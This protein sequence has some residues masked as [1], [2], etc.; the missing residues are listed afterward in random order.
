[1]VLD[2][3]YVIC[4]SLSVTKKEHLCYW[5]S[6]RRQSVKS[7]SV[8]FPCHTSGLLFDVGVC[9]LHW[10]ERC[11]LYHDMWVFTKKVSFCAYYIVFIDNLQVDHDSLLICEWR[12]FQWFK[13]CP[14]YGCAQQDVITPLCCYCG[15][16]RWCHECGLCRTTGLGRSLR[17][18]HA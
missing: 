3:F 17:Y 15:T 18:S 6:D 7:I 5:V 8:F 16:G 11:I 12:W 9:L 13:K 1:M 4:C 14:G 2:V 10:Y